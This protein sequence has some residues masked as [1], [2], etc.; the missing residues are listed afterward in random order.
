M[1]VENS[2]DPTQT[3]ETDVITTVAGDW[4]YL[5]FDFATEATGTAALSF[6][7]TNGWTYNMASIF[8]NFGVEGQA[9]GEKTYYFDDVVFGEVTNVSNQYQIEG[10]NIFPNPAID[11]WTIT[12]ENMDITSIEVYDLQGR[13]LL[14]IEPNTRNAVINA[15]D[16]A[17]GMYISKVSTELGTRS[18]KLIK[19]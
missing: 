10:L 7:L 18:M 6:G 1:K 12:S 14:F 17:T 8:F 16:F 11:Q 19:K 15:A 9:A 13:Q 5:V 2:N 4:E 3:C